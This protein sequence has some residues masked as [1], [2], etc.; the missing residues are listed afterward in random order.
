V[1]KD[2][3]SPSRLEVESDLGILHGRLSTKI[4]VFSPIKS[5]DFRDFSTNACGVG[6]PK[7]REKAQ[8]FDI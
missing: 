7:G 1:S 6:A 3:F 8:Y 4:S 5:C 2:R